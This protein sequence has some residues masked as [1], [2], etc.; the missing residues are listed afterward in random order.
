MP[1]RLEIDALRALLAISDHGGVTRAAT[2]LGLS[3]SAVSHKMRRLERTLDCELLARRAGGALF[4][5]TGERLCTHARRIIEAFKQAETGLVVIDGK[6]VEKPV[7]RDMHRILA[8]SD[9]ISA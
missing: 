8:I 5:D 1:E 3:Q 6:L 7:L 2:Q 4:T 9:R